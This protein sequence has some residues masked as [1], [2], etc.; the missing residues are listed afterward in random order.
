VRVINTHS[1]CLLLPAGHSSNTMAQQAPPP[2]SWGAIANWDAPPDAPPPPAPAEPMLATV[3]GAAP[4]P[5]DEDCADPNCADPM[6]A[7]L[8]KRVKGQPRASEMAPD[9]VRMQ[10]AMLGM[11]KDNRADEIRKLCSEQGLSAAYG[12]SIGQTALHIAAIWNAVESGEVLLEHGA[13]IN[14]KNDLS[15]ATR[16]PLTPPAAL[17]FPATPLPATCAPSPAALLRTCLR[18]CCQQYVCMIERSAV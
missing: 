6:C 1:S 15:G 7:P 11:A 9:K 4:A 8:R 16:E 2:M 10:E 5:F 14:A 17:L 18:F 12:N 13:L 3:R